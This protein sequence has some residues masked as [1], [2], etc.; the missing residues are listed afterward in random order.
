MIRTRRKGFSGR[1]K[2]D[3]RLIRRERGLFR[4]ARFRAFGAVA[5]VLCFLALHSWLKTALSNSEDHLPT[6]IKVVDEPSR[7][8]ARGGALARAKLSIRK[9]AQNLAPSKTLQED[10]RK[11]KAMFS[12]STTD[13]E[14]FMR[15]LHDR[16]QT[17]LENYHNGTAIILNLH[18]VHHGGTSFCDAIGRS[19]TAVGSTPAFAC[20][21]LSEASPTEPTLFNISADYPVENP[22][23]RED[24][25]PNIA[26][27]RKHFHMISW[28]YGHELPEHAI[29]YTDWDD[30]NLFSV[31]IVRD[32]MD[33]LLAGDAR[34]SM[35]YPGLLQGQGT[36]EQWE[37][38]S[39]STWTDNFALRVLNGH[40]CCQ[41]EHTDISFLYQAQDLAKRFSVVLDMECLT[42]SMLVLAQLLRIQPGRMLFK[43]Q[44][45]SSARERINRDH[46]YE[47]LL[48]RNKMDIQFYEWAKTISLVDCGA[49]KA[50]KTQ[51]R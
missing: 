36:D 42:Q 1:V 23:R 29:R 46:I 25:A 38:Y 9:R 21:K 20:W 11:A 37:S 39:Q 4:L 10:I 48:R 8:R 34:V 27:V 35:D 16:A 5:F 31:L 6:P 49:L 33:R 30:P 19:P 14:A 26:K 24:T 17:Q 18:I 51:G 43:H 32:P 3:G 44:Q 40:S 12:Q 47:K 41:G 7:R 45:R 28:E 50:T 13:Y 22:W 15:P 2:N